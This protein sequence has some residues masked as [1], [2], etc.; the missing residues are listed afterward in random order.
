MNGIWV[1]GFMESTGRSGYAQGSRRLH[2][3]S[4][5]M[6]PGREVLSPRENSVRPRKGK[7]NP[8][9][10]A[11]QPALPLGQEATSGLKMEL[12]VLLISS[13]VSPAES[14]FQFHQTY[15]LLPSLEGLGKLGM[16]FF[17]L[18][19]VCLFSCSYDVYSKIVWGGF[20][21]GLVWLF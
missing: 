2:G 12:S 4:I 6:A 20:F 1:T 13:R 3:V 18:F 14:S 10:I 5:G 15:W 16:L 17:N 8:R 9:G 11:G 21:K 7:G 19:F